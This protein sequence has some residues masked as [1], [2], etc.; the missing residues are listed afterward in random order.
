MAEKAEVKNKV[1]PLGLAAGLRERISA[2]SR[3][4]RQA[5]QAHG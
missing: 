3:Q 2:A 1:F 5:T 4:S